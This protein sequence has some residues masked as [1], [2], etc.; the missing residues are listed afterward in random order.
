MSADAGPGAAK[1]PTENAA[2]QA[3]TSLDRRLIYN[4]SLL[5]AADRRCLSR[6]E[7]PSRFYPSLQDRIAKVTARSGLCGKSRGGMAA[8][9]GAICLT[10][11][12]EPA[13]SM[14]GSPPA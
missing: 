5:N 9:N 13:P 12:L 11:G 8:R 4:S 6:S 10:L 7:R 3:A 14:V 2:A 1:M